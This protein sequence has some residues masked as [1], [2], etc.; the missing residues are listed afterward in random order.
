MIRLLVANGCSFTAGQEL[1]DRGTGAWPAVLAARLGV[2]VANLACGGGSNRRTVR[3]TV[4]NLDR[5]CREFGVPVGE[6]LVVC[7]WTGV[8]RGEY[9]RRDRVDRPDLPHETDWYR[10]G[11]WNLADDDG[12]ADEHFR[13]MWTREGGTITL[14]TDWVLLDSYLRSRGAVA[15]YTFAWD[16]LPSKLPGEAVELSRQL[17][18]TSVYGD[19]LGRGG[20]SFGGSTS[21]GFEFGPGGHP[22]EDGHAYFAQRLETWLRDQGLV[23]PVGAGLGAMA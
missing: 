19:A 11:P 16:L 10:L 6:T 12:A 1:R 20:T 2:P 15:R 17:D 5:V 14:L 23:F 18:P 8:N 22:L 3:T 4:G 9:H 13:S 21:G 7:M